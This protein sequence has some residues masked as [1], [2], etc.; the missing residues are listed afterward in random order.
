LAV[1]PVET[2][3]TPSPWSPRA[4][5]TTPVLSWTL[6][7]AR[8]IFIECSPAGRDV[9]SAF[10]EEPHGLRVDPML[11]D[12]DASGQRLLRVG[13]LHRYRSLQD[14]RPRVYPFVDEVDR[15]AGDPDAVVESLPLSV[16]SGERWQQR[17]MDV[18]QPSLPG[19]DEHRTEDAQEARETDE[20]DLVVFE[21]LGEHGVIGGTV[22]V[23]L[24]V[25][26]ERA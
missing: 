11:L 24:R 23:I 20:T 17:G 8:R 9:E 16:Q 4:S 15:G 14:D 21:R 13:R 7:N 25:H 22:A 1:P 3:S 26:E 6:I 10:G 2:I 18:H 19:A 12:Q 5:S